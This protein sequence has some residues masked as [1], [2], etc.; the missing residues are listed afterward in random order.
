MWIVLLVLAIFAALIVA[1][2][3]RMLAHRYI[4]AYVFDA[5]VGKRLREKHP[6]LTPEQH[7]LARQGLRDFLHICRQARLK[8]VSM[9]SQAVDELW[10][11]FILSTRHYREF[12]RRAFGR[13]LHHHPAET[14]NS[15][16]QATDG[17]RRAWQLACRREKIDP[18]N[19]DRLPRLFALDAQLG[20]AGGFVYTL[21]CMGPALAGEAGSSSSYC[22]SHIGCG[23]GCSAGCSSGCSSGCS[24]GDG[25]CGGG[26]D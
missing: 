7:E 17:I 2:R 8:G 16:T 23:S 25:G 13:Y 12:C 15:P 24:G 11:D 4:D 1:G 9:P 21:N 18:K 19:P 20:I 5:S 10:H 6:G 26:G 22:A 14:M 3:R